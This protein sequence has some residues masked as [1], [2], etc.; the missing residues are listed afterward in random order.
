MGMTVSDLGR[1]VGV[2]ADTVRYYERIGLLDPPDRTRS[3][4]RSYPDE[5]L[6]RL[7]FIKEGQ[8]VG[9]QLS[10]IKELLDVLDR[11]QCPCGHTLTLVERR[12]AQVR[13]EIEKLKHVEERLM[14]MACCPQSSSIW[15][16]PDDSVAERG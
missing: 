14:Q 3:G 11:G 6:D 10:D 7:R 13:A 5:A 16:C 2:K 8:R 12:L 4:Y 1:R 15:C 9:L